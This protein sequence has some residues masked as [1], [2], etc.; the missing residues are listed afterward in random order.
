MSYN[1]G[2]AN[3]AALEYAITLINDLQDSLALVKKRIPL[4]NYGLEINKSG[5]VV[6]SGYK[7]ECDAELI[8]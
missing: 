7:P 4:K 6:D 2:D 1:D 5:R 8:L 3:N